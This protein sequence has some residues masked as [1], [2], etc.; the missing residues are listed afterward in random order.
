LLGTTYASRQRALKRYTGS[1]ESKDGIF[2]FNGDTDVILI[3]DGKYPDKNQ[4]W[5]VTKNLLGKYTNIKTIGIP[6]SAC[7]C[8]STPHQ[9]S[10]TSRT[11]GVYLVKSI[12]LTSDHRDGGLSERWLF[13]QVPQ[14]AT[15]RHLLLLCLLPRLTS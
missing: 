11:F 7:I 5:P 8:K 15:S 12:M 13:L 6:A 2:R 14:F 10:M 4:P 3:L 1:I 9:R